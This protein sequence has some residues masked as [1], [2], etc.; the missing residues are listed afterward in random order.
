MARYFPDASTRDHFHLP[1]TFSALVA[2]VVSM[3]MHFARALKTLEDVVVAEN[4]VAIRSFCAAVHRCPKCFQRYFEVQLEIVKPVEN[5]SSLFT[6]IFKKSIFLLT[7]FVCFTFLCA[8]KF[9]SDEL[10]KRSSCEEL[11]LQKII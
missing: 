5:N 7:N 1:R 3:K 8:F 6:Q 2:V 4:L 11:N 9:C 10:F